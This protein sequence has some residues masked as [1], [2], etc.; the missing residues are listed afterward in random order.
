MVMKSIIKLCLGFYKLI[1]IAVLC[2]MFFTEWSGVHDGTRTV[3]TAI[4]DSVVY[5]VIYKALM[6]RFVI[7]LLGKL[8]NYD[9]FEGIAQERRRLW[10]GKRRS[11]RNGKQQNV[12]DAKRPIMQSFMRTRQRDT[13]VQMTDTGMKTWRRNIGMM[14]NGEVIKSTHKT[15]TGQEPRK[16]GSYYFE[17]EPN[18]LYIL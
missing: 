9:P 7:G 18:R 17:I 8:F 1:V 14:R 13:L 6:S 2:I 5:L 3:T 12:P 10:H 16:R 4:I 11:R 15:Y